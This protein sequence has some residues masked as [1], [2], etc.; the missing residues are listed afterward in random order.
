MSEEP[1]LGDE[2]AAPPRP[3]FLIT[4]EY[5]RFAEFADA[6]RRDHYIGVCYGPAGVGRGAVVPDPATEA[7]PQ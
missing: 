3:T 2:P 6:C 7:V 4:K 1:D 5:R